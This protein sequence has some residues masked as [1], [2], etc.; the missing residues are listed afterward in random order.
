MHI[1]QIFNDSG[2]AFSLTKIR[3]SI[4]MWWWQEIFDN[5]NTITESDSNLLSPGGRH[6]P[7][8]SKPRLFLPPSTIELSRSESV[9]T[10]IPLENQE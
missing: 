2:S 7:I 10:S 9:D 3:S 6:L 5:K 8:R 1:N 4:A